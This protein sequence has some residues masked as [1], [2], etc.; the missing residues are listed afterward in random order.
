MNDFMFEHRCPK[1]KDLGWITVGDNEYPCECQR[2]QPDHER[3]S[4]N[5]E[6]EDY[7]R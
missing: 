2:A 7:D 5:Y 3:P 6:D 4:Y 1:C